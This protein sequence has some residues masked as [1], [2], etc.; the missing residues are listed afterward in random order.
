MEE[1]NLNEKESLELISQM[2]RN[3]QQRFERV[4]AAPF[5]AF[6]YGTV[7]VSVVVWYLLTRTQNPIWNLVWLMIPVLGFAMQKF[8]FPKR[9]KIVKTYV[10]KAIDNVW[11]VIGFTMLFVGVITFFVNIDVMPTIVLLMG[12]AMALTGLMAKL[13]II[14]YSGILGILSS[15]L[16]WFRVLQGGDVILL[17]AAVFFIFMV[18]PGHILYAQKEGGRHV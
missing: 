11:S 17:F 7:I 15:A 5:L 1:R 10:D 13:P 9:K 18:V 3:T 2:I 8:I 4:N 16:F 12:M 6:G 14:K